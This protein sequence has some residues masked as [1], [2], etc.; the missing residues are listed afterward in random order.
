MSSPSQRVVITGMGLVSP[1]GL[2]LD[3]VW[4][5]LRSGTS[6]IRPLELLPTEALPIDAGGEARDFTGS[7]ENYGPL[8]KPLFKSIKKSMKVMCREIAMGV[9]ASQMAVSHANLP[10]ERNPDRCGCLFG[11]DY[12]IT[13]PEE[14]EDGF[15]NCL[16]ERGDL[17]HADWPEYGLGKV[18]P[19]WLLKYLPN[20]PNSHVSI[21]NDLRGPNNALTVR[22]ASMGLAIGEARN[23]IQRGAADV[24][25]VGSTGCRIHPMRTPQTIMID[26]FAPPR[27]NCAEM[28][29]PFDQDCGGMVVGEGAGVLILESFE[30]AESRGA[31]IWGEVLATGA[32]MATTGDGEMQLTKALTRV[33]Q[34]AI[35]DCDMPAKWHVHAQGSSLGWADQAEARAISA[36]LDSTEIPVTAA[37]SFVGHSGA[38]GAAVEL[39]YSLLAMEKGELFPILNLENPIAEAKWKAAQAGEPAGQAVVQPSFTLQGQT[40]CVVI[41]TAS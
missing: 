17:N 25:L 20:M 7:I 38:G 36:A 21:F 23:I 13:R 4:Q 26:K 14:Y 34:Q 5:N 37:K 6:G 16:A 15:R 10:A 39:I 22:E 9:A 11:C 24:M 35:S 41:G 27:D 8:E 2:D 29:R 19:L 30:H 3:Q 40:A 18:N 32:G 12:I 1:L 31:K 28:S 33:M